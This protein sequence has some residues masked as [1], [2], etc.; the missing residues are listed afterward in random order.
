MNKNSAPDHMKSIEFDMKKRKGFMRNVFESTDVRNQEAPRECGAHLGPGAYDPPHPKDIKA[1]GG[2]GKSAAKRPKRITK[3]DVA[4]AAAGVAKTSKDPG[5]Y[6]VA[7]GTE[8]HLGPGRYFRTAWAEEGFRK[9]Q[10]QRE[11]QIPF[12]TAPRFRDAPA[13]ES[14][15]RN[16][17][18]TNPRRSLTDWI[19]PYNPI[20][21]KGPADRTPYDK[22]TDNGGD[23]MP[24]LDT[25]NKMSLATKSRTGIVGFAG[26]FKS[27]NPRLAEPGSV[28]AA[29]R[30]EFVPA[31]AGDRLGP[32]A[33]DAREPPSDPPPPFRSGEQR[34]DVRVWSDGFAGLRPRHLLKAQGHTALLE[35]SH[36]DLKAHEKPPPKFKRVR[37]AHKRRK[38]HPAVPRTPRELREDIYGAPA[39]FP[40]GLRRC[41]AASPLTLDLLAFAFACVS[42]CRPAEDAQGQG[43]R[44]EE[45]G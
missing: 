28:L 39:R 9:T 11:P 27:K 15:K 10:L 32:G 29:S 37:E 33:Y 6:L 22:R 23:Y 19:L 18:N 1:E 12:S 35:T 42:V 8:P 30:R 41:R 16:G 13:S 45:A 36:M 21:R 5:S 31:T 20:Y 25:L 34:G 7:G 2:A 17:A 14:Y 38:R 24:M 4:A 26:V 3:A 44:A 40:R 43:H